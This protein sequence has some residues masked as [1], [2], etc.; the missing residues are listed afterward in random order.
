MSPIYYDGQKVLIDRPRLR[1]K[2]NKEIQLST[3]KAFQCP[4]KMKQTV[5]K[6][7]ELGISSRNYEEAIE[8]LVSGYGIKK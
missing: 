2:D 5:M 4:R 3:Y 7:M 8:T 6:Q 1:G